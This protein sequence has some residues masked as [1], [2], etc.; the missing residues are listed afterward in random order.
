MQMNSIRDWMGQV[1]QLLEELQS[2][3][4]GYP[5]GNNGFIPAQHSLTLAAMLRELGV[6]SN[7]VFRD[8]YSACNGL[9]LPGVHVG[10]FIS[11]IERIADVTQDFNP[12]IVTGP[13]GGKVISIGSSGGGDLFVIRLKEQ[14][15]LLLSPGFIQ[16]GIYDGSSGKVRVVATSFS[17][18]LDRILADTTAFVKGEPHSYL[19][20]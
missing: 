9:N 15:V 8:F 11:P 17:A 18:F 1:E 2:M 5:T 16:A 13:L 3:D 4:F 7:E 6:Y 14:D 20:T 19:V 12:R 10:Y